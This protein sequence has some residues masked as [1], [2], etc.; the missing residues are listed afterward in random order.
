MFTKVLRVLVVFIKAIIVF[1][2]T[3]VL[4]FLQFFFPL[5]DKLRLDD[6]HLRQPL[7]HVPE[8]QLAK[9]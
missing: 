5:F 2:A 4:G 3:L 6:V 1:I 8:Q 9:V 7:D